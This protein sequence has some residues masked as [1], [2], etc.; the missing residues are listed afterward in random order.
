[1]VFY[2][3][4]ADLEESIRCLNPCLQKFDS[5]CFNGVYVTPEV[6]PE[7]LELVENSR[8]KGRRSA[9]ISLPPCLANGCDDPNIIDILVHEGDEEIYEIAPLSTRSCESIQNMNSDTPPAKKM[10]TSQL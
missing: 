3:D 7:L 10:K 2:N 6:T 5:S 1:M 9:S 4:L 8:G